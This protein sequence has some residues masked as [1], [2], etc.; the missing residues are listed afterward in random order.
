MHHKKYR[1][2]HIAHIDGICKKTCQKINALS[3]VI[4]Y[5][6]IT[7][8]SFIKPFL[9]P[10]FNYCP[11]TWICRSS[12]KIAKRLHERC[13][14]IICNA[15]IFTFAQLLEK[16]SSVSI[17][18]RNLRFLAVEMLKVVKGLAPKIVSDLF[19]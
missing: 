19:P 16:D 15:K 17:H 5:V 9:I 3:R 14:R 1:H 11:L 4:L 8:H 18:T 10:Q 2:A 7:A 13:L 6:N 12:A